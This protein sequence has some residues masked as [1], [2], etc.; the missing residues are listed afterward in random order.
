MSSRSSHTWIVDQR[1]NYIG[2]KR[3]PKR[4]PK[5]LQTHYVPTY[6]VKN[7]TG[8]NKG[9]YLFLDDR[10]RI[11][12]WGTERILQRIQR[13]RRP[14][15]YWWAHPQQEQDQTEKSSYGLDWLQKGVWYGPTR[16]DNKLPRNVENIR[17]S[18]KLY[19]ENHENLKSVIDSR[20]E[21][22][23]WSKDTKMYISKKCPITIIIYN[24]DDATQ[25]HT[26]PDTN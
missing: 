3:P 4:N 21:K 22:F 25:P 2:P 13:H 17:W 15:L 26:Q 11:V 20:K 24:I 1:K 7:T 14:T 18:H 16:L 23:R 5:Q 8:T 9:R 12:P 10:P 19:R 6:N